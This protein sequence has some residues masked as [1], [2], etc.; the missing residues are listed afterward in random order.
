MISLI[1]YTHI[2]LAFSFH[3]LH[4]A[5]IYGISKHIFLY[6]NECISLK[7]IFEIYLVLLL[8]SYFT[9]AFFSLGLLLWYIFPVFSS[10]AMSSTF[11][12]CHSHFVPHS[13]WSTMSLTISSSF[14]RRATGVYF[15]F[16]QWSWKVEFSWTAVNFNCWVYFLH[17][18]QLLNWKYCAKIYSFL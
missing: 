10:L 13:C 1:S 17:F 4:S 5:C 3:L 9:V 11:P 6:I 18:F 2:F 16:F 8:L 7:Y 14:F 12:L 15:S